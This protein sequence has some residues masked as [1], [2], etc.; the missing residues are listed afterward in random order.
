MEES[1]LYTTVLLVT[2][3]LLWLAWK[4]PD[5]RLRLLRLVTSAGALLS[6]LFMALPPHLTRPVTR[7]EAILLTPGYHPDTLQ[8]LRNKVGD[9]TK[10]FD[11]TSGPTRYTAVTS[12]AVITQDFPRVNRLHVLGYGLQENDLQQLRSIQI[13]PHLNTLPAGIINLDWTRQLTAGDKLIVSG[14]YHQTVDKLVWLYLDV[15]G[16]TQDSTLITRNGTNRFNL[17]YLPK[18]AGRYVYTLHTRMGQQKAFAGELPVEVKL[19]TKLR[20]LLLPSGP[21]FE[22]KF[23]KNYLA[24]EQHGVALRFPV[25]KNISQ[26]E[27]LNLPAAPLKT[28]NSALLKQFDLLI[29][30]TKT[31]QTLP[32][33]ERQIINQAG[34]NSGLGL[35]I[36]PETLPLTFSPDFLT[37]FELVRSPFSNLG[38]E[39]TKVSWMDYTAPAQTTPL[40]YIIKATPNLKELVRSN[41]GKVLV[42]TKQS[43]WGKIT[44]N[45]LPQTYTWLLAGNQ[46]AYASFWS[47]LIKQ[48]AKPLLTDHTWHVTA[49]PIAQVN[50]AL[51]LSLSDNN[52]SA[53]FPFPNGVVQ[54]VDQPADTVYLAQAV[55]LPHRFTGTFWPRTRG[56]HQVNKPVHA[57][58][59][60]YVF[61]DAS[62]LAWQQATC[63]TV[64]RNFKQPVVVKSKPARQLTESRP[65]GAIYFFVTFL[66]CAGFLWLEEKW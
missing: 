18:E 26:T 45:L 6:L 52:Y 1:I 34:Q 59:F 8:K 11:Y 13:I 17:S 46:S 63:L 41:T 38:P 66:I 51:K 56:W 12:V 7:T 10:I 29:T 30:D 61:K 40:P 62:F 22:V 31:L 36:V 15:A 21:S 54:A 58:Y 32:T 64:T 43:G 44:L 2:L 42:A 50:H 16:K 48:T 19:K 9:A 3:L 35:I 37:G 28:I 65:I 39:A 23:L 24:A 5:R 47:L 14:R 57:P 4:R 49:H 60:F 53:E 55:W 25:S 20:V 27:W 33:R